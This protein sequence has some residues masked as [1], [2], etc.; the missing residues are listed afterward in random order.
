MKS[1]PLCG[2]VGFG[3]ITCPV[4]RSTYDWM[5]RYGREALRGIP[6]GCPVGTQP[7]SIHHRRIMDANLYTGNGRRWR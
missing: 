7:G 6:I 2:A 1:C 5:S 4:C 3:N